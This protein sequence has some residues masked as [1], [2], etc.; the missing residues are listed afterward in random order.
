MHHSLVGPFGLALACCASLASAQTPTAGAAVIYGRINTG[1]ERTDI[2]GSPTDRAMTRLSNYRSV[3]GFRGEEALG[4][5]LKA[6]W[7]I[8]GGFALDTGVGS[9]ASRNTHIGLA[10]SFGTLFLGVWTLP[11]TSATSG[12]DPFY[13]TTAG[14][15]AIMGNGSASTTD[16]VIDTS[17]FDRRQRNQIQY[18]SPVWSGL[19]AR[20]AYGFNEET[21]AD[22]GAKPSLF[23]AS[24]S[25]DAGGLTLTAA[26]ERHHEYQAASTT[27]TASKLGAAYR[28]GAA[29]LAGVVERLEYETATGSLERNAW[30]VSGTYRL[31]SGSFRIG[32]ARAAD[33]KGSA[34]E[35]IGFFSSGSNT[36]ASQVTVGYEH[37]LSKR[38]AL[39]AFY[40]RIDN[41]S[42]AI[43]DFAINELGAAAGERPSV[44]SLGMRH[45]F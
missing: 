18:W 7:Q 10:G 35:T 31:G 32:Y 36:G 11:Y 22:T 24:V 16:N 14:Y 19:S 21:V 15:M 2:S 20:I 38:T 17:S 34:A 41:D 27:D 43:H 6:V 23:S 12:F 29:R 37:E 39:F 44:F 40:S 25:F 45:S 26:H 30:Y 8:E 33:G 3:V 42:A 9:I 4:G 28:F 13:P 5:G 1:L